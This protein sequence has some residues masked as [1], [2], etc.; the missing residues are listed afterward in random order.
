MRF[1]NPEYY[2]NR[3]SPYHI[4][5]RGFTRLDKIRQ[6]RSGKQQQRAGHGLRRL[7]V[8]GSDGMVSLAALPMV[9]RPGRQL[10]N[11]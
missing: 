11:A 4:R 7:V 3:L 9:G 8:I 1:G 2:L 10:R 6:M 5:G